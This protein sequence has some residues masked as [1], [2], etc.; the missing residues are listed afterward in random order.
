[1]L[2]QKC[3]ENGQQIINFVSMKLSESAENWSTIEKE[4]FAMFSEQ[5]CAF[6]LFFC[7]LSSS[8]DSCPREVE[9]KVKG[10]KSD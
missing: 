5:N 4:A 2:I 10:K 8:L 3:P 1:V 7:V 9:R 6:V